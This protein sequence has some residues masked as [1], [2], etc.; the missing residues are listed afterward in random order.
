M[1]QL[2]KKEEDVIM[3]RWNGKMK[4]EYE[5]FNQKINSLEK[6]HSENVKKT[7]QIVDKLS[8]LKL[9]LLINMANLNKMKLQFI[10]KTD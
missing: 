9:I 4:K 2:L 3:N 10:P 6:K 7:Q 8:E 5:C 1:S